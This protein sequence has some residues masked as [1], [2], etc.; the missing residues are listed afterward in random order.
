MNDRRQIF[1]W[2]MYDWANSAY[3]T[4]VT[5]A[6]LPIFFTNVVVGPE[7]FRIGGFTIRASILWGWMI[8]VASLISFVVA[9]FLGAISDFSATKKKFLMVFC[10]IG[11]ISAILL[12]TA[13]EGDVIRT[14]II[15]LVA[16]V[17]FVSGNVF[18][19]AFLPQIA[20]EDRIDW[21]S[22]LGFAW[23]Y[24]GGGLQFALSIA[25]IS[26][27]GFFGISQI[28][29]SRIAMASAGIWWGAFAIVTFST[30]RE[31]S[32]AM[33]MPARYRGMNRIVA[34]I[35]IG[36]DRTLSTA[37]HVGRFKHLVLFLVSFMIY[38]NGI[39]SVITLATAYGSDE[40]KFSP[41]DLM[42]TLLIIQ[43]VAFFGSLMFGKLAQRLSA[44]T[45]LLI[46][47]LLWSGV[48]IYAYFMTRPLEYYIL[49]IVVGLSMGGSQ[50]LSRSLYGSMIPV[51]A[52]A[53]F[54]GFYSVFS[55]FSAILGPFTFA[56][57]GM[58]T[59][60]L[61]LALLSLIVFF[62][63]GLILL[64]AVDVDR[65]REARTAG[66]FDPAAP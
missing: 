17:G 38:N 27:H 4:T 23:G 48:I 7:G 34:V 55:K 29:A 46:T 3:I 42:L 24:I 53:E 45:A 21:V 66:I 63:L 28:T 19:D 20:S 31:S 9:P 49:G 36:I 22:G 57:F 15:F 2:A 47:L 35:R 16:Q 51:E 14:M 54:Y 37:R 52:S 13:G 41:T 64:A 32:V 43:F 25:L 5:V 8:G 65:A 58:V 60:S 11:S 18:Y 39:Q 33:P 12:Y 10:Y 6:V 30:L 50:A 26:F 1:G 62:I 40:L 61:R 44:K 56:L 59:G